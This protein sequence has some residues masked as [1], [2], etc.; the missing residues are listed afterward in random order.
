LGAHA[1]PILDFVERVMSQ[2]NDLQAA[3]KRGLKPGADLEQELDT[4]SD[5]SIHTK[6]DAL[7]VIDVLKTFPR[8]AEKEKAVEE[9]PSDAEDAEIC[10]ALH[11]LLALFQMV[12]TEEAFEVM[13]MQGMP[14]L[15]RIYDAL[16]ADDIEL[17]AANL[18]FMLKVYVM[19]GSRGGADRVVQAARHSQM[20][21]SWMWS[22]IFEQ[23]NI[24]WLVEHFT[25]QLRDPLPE[26]FAAVAFLDF[27]NRLAREESLE[28]HPFNT[29][30]GVRRLESWL[31]SGDREEDSFAHS[32]TASLPYIEEPHRGRLLALALDHEDIGVQMEAAWASAMVGGEAGVKVL[33][34]RCLDCNTATVA[35]EYLR[36]LDRE[37]AIPEESNEPDFLSMAEMCN[38]L[39]HP[40]E[41]GRTPDRIELFDTREMFW[42]PTNDRR[43]LWIFHYWY[44]AEI[45]TE[46]EDEEFYGDAYTSDF[47]D[48]FDEDFD[49]ETGDADDASLENTIGACGETTDSGVGLV[50]GITFSLFGE[51]NIHQP[52]ED[53]YGVHCCWELQ[54]NEDPR[55]P[56]KYSAEEGRRILQKYEKF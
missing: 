43:T 6:E 10:G 50:G 38:W 12:Q 27:V 24:P 30:Q 47:D 34:R 17:H 23:L 25:E 39:S 33:A 36:E 48:E 46:E 55:A 44:D 5:Q 22:V 37:D 29:P 54:A 19:Y 41:Y 51:T 40:N 49:Q 18:N 8:E 35:R 53:V 16:L 7:A 4:V 42:P 32:A 26:G 28:Y 11:S 20:Q 21:D 9:E 31:S 1:I 15:H 2:N 14:E 56:E 45:E 13:G 3:L 52:P